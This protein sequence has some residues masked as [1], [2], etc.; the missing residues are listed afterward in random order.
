MSFTDASFE[1]DDGNGFGEAALI[2]RQRRNDTTVSLL[3]LMNLTRLVDQRYLW[4]A[5]LRSN[6]WMIAGLKERERFAC[7]STEAMA[8][9]VA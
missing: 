8:R 7:K 9:F 3:N 5:L 1:V 6:S 4:K 2:G